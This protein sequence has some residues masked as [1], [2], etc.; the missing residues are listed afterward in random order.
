MARMTPNAYGMA[1]ARTAALR[2]ED[3]YRQVGAC[4]MRFDRTVVSLGYNGPPPGVDIDWED[5]DHRRDYV[6]HAEVNALRFAR[7]NEVSFIYTTS[8][9]CDRCML[10]I[11]AYGVAVVVYDEELDPA[12]YDRALIMRIADL[13]EVGVYKHSEEAATNG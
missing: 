8:L 10:M 13:A 5:R 7:P 11:A 12:V 9:P 6:V 4:A 1:L 3:P 2:S